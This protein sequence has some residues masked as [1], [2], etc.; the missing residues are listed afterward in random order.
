MYASICYSSGNSDP[1][2]AKFIT[3]G[4]TGSLK[5][6]W[7]NIITQN[8]KDE[9]MASIKVE[10]G[11]V[12]PDVV[13]TLAQTIIEHFIGSHPQRFERGRKLL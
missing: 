6:W 12:V 3:N 8:Q 2:V 10:N 4:F 9:I 1:N 13:L 5:G 7:D 11:A